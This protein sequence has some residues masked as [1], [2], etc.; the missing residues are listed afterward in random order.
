MGETQQAR[1]QIIAISAVL[2]LTILAID[3]SLPL[4]VAG[5]VPYVA[6]VLVGWW[7]EKPR[8]I[9]LL[10][11]VSSALTAAGY[12]YSPE[13][14]ISWMVLANRFLALFAIWVTAGLL[15]RA[16]GAEMALRESEVR[17][18][19]I[20]EESPVSIWEEDWS[21]TKK[22]IA[23]LADKGVRD[24]RRYFDDHPGQLETAYD[25]ARVVDVSRV[26]L[27]VYRAPDKD[28]LIARSKAKHVQ[29]DELR[30]FRDT[31][32][33]FVEGETSFEVEAKSLAFDNSPIMTRSRVVI[34][35]AY[36]ETWSRVLYAI[37]DIAERRRAQRLSTRLGRII[38]DSVNEIYVFDSQNLRF[39]QVNRGARENLGYSMDELRE[40]TS[41]DLKP[42]ITA[43]GFADLVRPLHEGR[44]DQIVF[45]TLH[46]RKDGST[47]DVEVRLQ[48]SPS[49]TPP[50]FFAIVEDVTDRKKAEAD[51]QAAM[52]EADHANRA[53]S[54]FI[55]NM[56]H[57]LRTP[58]NA[59][60]GF[61]EIIKSETFGPVGSLRYRDY[62]K[63]IN[64]SGQHLLQLINDMLDI[65]KI[66]AGRF[67][68]NEEAVDV[69][70]VVGS[71][72]TLVNEHAQNAGPTLETEIADGL[73]PLRADAR[74]H[75]QILLNLLSNAVKFTAAGGTVTTRV[76]CRRDDGYVF[77]VAD[78]GI[79][80]APEDIPKVL[81][82]FGQVDGTLARKFEG[83]GLGLPLTK[84]LVEMHGGSLD[85]QSEEGA[86]TTVTVRFPKERIVYV[87]EIEATGY[88]VA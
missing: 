41:L 44:Q 77:Q 59:I 82:P 68:L 36:R 28:A 57:E 43:K 10:A 22:L 65:A 48:L 32:I 2:A 16:K 79:G 81:S 30:A 23:T 27:D 14:G 15:A 11:V 76:W 69:A 61:S 40:L 21:A 49:E 35:P 56:S 13:G 64:D 5:G 29:P 53:K 18:R 85:L 20:F 33:A 51:L 63:D 3:L 19:E 38:E 58:L 12:L 7:L 1:P 73:P 34:P 54:E 72:L 52:E 75:K 50:V 26:N 66:E 17:Y 24:W 39:I 70:T 62:A 8:H 78:T 45:T 6:L 74:K 83:T 86:G 46:R 37:E 84:S 88:P 71:C 42:E 87:S 25:L 67:D 47:Y 4:G 55:A 9:L 60:I 31:L 80:I